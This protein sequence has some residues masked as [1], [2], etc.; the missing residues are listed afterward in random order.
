MQVYSIY[1]SYI[2]Q[3]RDEVDEDDPSRL[4]DSSHLISYNNRNE[5]EF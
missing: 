1:L 4:S 5:S 3:C 2:S